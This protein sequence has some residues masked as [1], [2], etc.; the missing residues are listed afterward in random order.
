MLD[1]DWLTV[2]ATPCY[3]PLDE[4]VYD[5]AEDTFLLLDSLEAHLGLDVA[6]GR[7]D[8]ALWLSFVSLA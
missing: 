4:D 3:G 1:S 8:V 2:M 6:Q 7:C 5:P